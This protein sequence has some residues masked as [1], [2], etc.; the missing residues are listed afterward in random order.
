[1][2]RIHIGLSGWS[3]RDWVG[4]FYPEDLPAD[5]W[6]PFVADHFDTVEVNRSFYSLLDPSTYRSWYEGVPDGFVF[7]LKGSR[8]ITHMKKLHDVETP[9]ANFF[10][11]GVLELGD[12]L[13]PVLW[14]LPARWRFQAERVRDFI[15]LLPTTTGVAAG[16]A[17]R[18]DERVREPATES[19]GDRPLR[20]VMEVRDPSFFVPELL[21]TLMERN[22]AFAI[23]HSSAWPYTEDVIGEIAYLR[24]H[25]P[26][27]LYSS[28][29]SEADLA[30]W[31]RLVAAWA[32][33][34]DPADGPRISSGANPREDGRDVFVYFDNDSGAHAPP[35]ALR[36][37]QLVDELDAGTGGSG[38]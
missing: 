12:K 28:P 30:R 19:H 3:Y 35:D 14:Q 32:T 2:S 10:A 21:E 29:Y 36:L 31:A 4:R 33:G 26:A 17:A 5:R 38:E 23:S 1:M 15:S 22:V 25:G 20:H 13:G 16:L 9:M 18:H 27:A 24:L 6:L 8:Y 37:R 7:A 34:T 11:S